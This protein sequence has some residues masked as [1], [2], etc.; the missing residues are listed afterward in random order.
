MLLLVTRKEN[1]KNNH[2]FV[3]VNTMIFSVTEHHGISVSMI[4]TYKDRHNMKHNGGG[5]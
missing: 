1:T 3:S 2:S 4:M 5:F